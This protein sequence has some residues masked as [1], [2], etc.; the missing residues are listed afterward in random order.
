LKPQ[1]IPVFVLLENFSVLTKLLAFL[2]ALLTLQ[3]KMEN[4]LAILYSFKSE[5]PV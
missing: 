4:V 1:G 5:M 2:L 3:A